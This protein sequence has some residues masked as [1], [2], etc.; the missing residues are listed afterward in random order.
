MVD[1]KQATIIASSVLVSTCV[2]LIILL[3]YL[4]RIYKR[5]THCFPDTIK[6][7]DFPP[8]QSVSTA[9]QPLL[10]SVESQE[11]D[12]DKQK[13]TSKH[14][15][16]RSTENLDGKFDPT[17]YSAN[18]YHNSYSRSTFELLRAC[19]R[20]SDDLD[21]SGIKPEKHPPPV[22]NKFSKS[23]DNLEDNYDKYGA[24]TLHHRP[25][26]N[27][28]SM[29]NL[30][31]SFSS[32]QIQRIKTHH[33]PIW[34]NRSSQYRDL[35]PR[36]KGPHASSTSSSE[37]LE[38][39]NSCDEKSQ[40]LTDD[41]ELSERPSLGEVLVSLCH[42]PTEGRLTITIKRAEGLQR[43]SHTGTINPFIKV[44]VYDCGERKYNK[45]TSIKHHTTSPKFEESFNFVV[46]G[47]RMPQTSVI[48]QI[49][50]RRHRVSVA[51]KDVLIGVVFLG[52]QFELNGRN[53]FM[54]HQ[55]A[56]HWASILEKPLLPIEE[57]HPIQAISSSS[58]RVRH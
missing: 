12:L 25:L 8:Y 1:H 55:G 29:D 27:C 26:T 15:H 49:Y 37:S 44:R 53:P 5:K 13:L 42:N 11:S 31:T 32:P 35:S 10:K 7:P 56:R 47:S 46:T 19:S 16:S 41:S 43:V 58:E 57:W 6:H 24:R 51:K 50:H 34:R 4:V 21:S 3:V 36:L 38:N 22:K 52:Y 17:Q 54:L 33:K 18:L 45:K 28:V 39:A 30:N 2:I 14:G 40:S 48:L 20:S 9:V 23:P